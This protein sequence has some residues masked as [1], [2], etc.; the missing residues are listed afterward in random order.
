MIG[1]QPMSCGVG[2]TLN[3]SGR[4]GGGPPGVHVVGGNS[5]GLFQVTHD[6]DPRKETLESRK[7]MPVTKETNR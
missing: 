4:L 2:V 7:S 3:C 6:L 5:M 1:L